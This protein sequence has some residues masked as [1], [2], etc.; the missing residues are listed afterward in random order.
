MNFNFLKKITIENRWAII[1]G[2]IFSLAFAPFHLLLAAM[3]SLSFFYILLEQ[4]DDKKQAFYL[5]LSYG[6][7]YFLS[8]LY[9]ITISL[10]VDVK[11]FAWI[12]PFAIILIP[13]ILGLYIALFAFS[14]KFLVIRFNIVQTYRKIILFALLWLVFE[15]LR[16]NL[17]S[18]FPWNL[19]GYIWLVDVNFAQSAKIFGIY[20]LSLFAVFIC[21]FPVIFVNK[22]HIKN[23]KEVLLGD[24]ILAI[25]LLLLFVANYAFGYFSIKQNKLLYKND[26]NLRLVQGNIKQNLKWDNEQKYDNF[27][28]HISLSNSKNLDN[29]NAVIWPETAIPYVVDDSADLLEFLKQAIP[30]NGVLISGGLKLKYNADDSQVIK[31]NNS[32]FTFDN[33]GI[34]DSYDKHHLV[35][36]GEYIP[37]QKYLPFIEKITQ[38]SVG[39]DK[40]VGAKTIKTN[41]FSFSPLICY[42]VIFSNST[43]NK[44]ARPDLL[45]NLTN[46]A[47]FGRSSG[48]YQHFNMSKMRAIEYG[49]PLAR[50]AN[51]GITAF[52]DPFGRVLKQINLNQSG[53]FDIK[54]IEKLEATI[55]Q[56]YQY[57]PLMLI[58]GILLF[59]LMFVQKVS[60]VINKFSKQS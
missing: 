34:A 15:I 51:T 13:A 16:S 14:Y 43:I 59:I 46:D 45:L 42:E 10:F 49:I 6:F 26:V 40:G 35:P 38:G 27:M 55:Y 17:F 9:W 5:G 52:I 39:F 4:S 11:S 57:G 48:P 24:K 60:L 58:F 50:V 21:L 7:G 18:G 47:W 36:F 2:A 33:N 31:A 29:I 20:G 28:K 25:I 19:V 30:K 1:A 32:I 56:K 37:L 41:S 3:L 22:G 44:K 54:L 8:G 53:F 23:N 12:V